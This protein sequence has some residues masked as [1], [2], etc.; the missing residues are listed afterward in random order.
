MESKGANLY[1]VPKIASPKY[2]PTRASSRKHRLQQ[3]R[4]RRTSQRMA[5]REISTA[6]SRNRIRCRAQ[7]AVR[8]PA[9]KTLRRRSRSKLAATSIWTPS[10]RNSKNDA[11][12][13]HHQ[14]RHQR[15]DAPS[16]DAPSDSSISTP[17]K[18]SPNMLNDTNMRSL[19]A[20]LFVSS[21]I[22][23]ARRI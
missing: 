14:P 5:P 3:S 21:A 10:G 18:K 4:W 13:T 6:L 16:P 2:P 23:E 17:R 12:A 8:P 20:T 7:M 22:S 11:L 9:G 19:A 15:E 1:S